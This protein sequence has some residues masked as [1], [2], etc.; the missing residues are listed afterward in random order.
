[1]KWYI[2]AIVRNVKACKG[3]ELKSELFETGMGDFFA[4]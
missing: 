1:M 2:L 3:S 4:I